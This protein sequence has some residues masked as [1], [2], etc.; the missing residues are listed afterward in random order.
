[1]II[2]GLADGANVMSR[3]ATTGVAGAASRLC[4]ARS[5]LTDADIVQIFRAAVA[6]GPSMTDTE[7]E[8][9]RLDAVCDLGEDH[10]GRHASLQV[11]RGMKLAD[12]WLRWD[13]HSREIMWSASECPYSPGDPTADEGSCLLFAGHPGSHHVMD[14][15]DGGLTPSWARIPFPG[16]ESI[17]ESVHHKAP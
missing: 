4:G 13:D 12:P 5:G 17:T 11:I 10:P 7:F 16:G 9:M 6:S 2:N 8:S 15:S 3:S 1:M 14:T